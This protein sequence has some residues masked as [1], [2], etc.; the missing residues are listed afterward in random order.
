MG[1]LQAKKP[2]ARRTQLPS[3]AFVPVPIDDRYKRASMPM[4]RP[5]WWLRCTRW[6]AYYRIQLRWDIERRLARLF[7]RRWGE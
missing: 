7:N 5:S 2:T 6:I 1:D 4:Q 3:F